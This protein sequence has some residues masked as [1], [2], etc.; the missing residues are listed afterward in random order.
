MNIKWEAEDY[1]S[2]FSFVYK[3][4]ENVLDLIDAPAPANELPA[5]VAAAGSDAQAGAAQPTA[6]AEAESR[7][8]V[9][10][11]A[12]QAV[13]RPAV[14]EAARQAV[15]QP[16][17][18]ADAAA[19]RA[20][21][22][23]RPLAVDLGCGTG[24]L[25]EKLAA[26]GFDVIG[27]DDSADMLS[28]AEDAHPKLRFQK[29]NALDFRL[30]S[31]ADVIFSNAVFHWIDAA[32]QQTLAANLY[33]NL[34]PGGQLV[35]EFGGKGCAEAVHGTLEKCFAARGLTYPRVF[36]FPTIGE[37]A[38]ILEKAGFRVEAAYLF[39]RPT[40]QRGEDGLRRWIDMFIKKPF[41]NIDPDTKSRII[42]D[43]ES[44]LQPV[45]LRD[46]TWFIDYVRIRIKAVKN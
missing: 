28:V 12:R 7:P 25:T 19:A 27:I 20:G 21:A 1:R 38:P 32:D 3:Y 35:C 40:P 18:S 26:M 8:A 42:A 5:A 22:S 34:K 13:T 41:E 14:A 17:R 37:Y 24:A 4:G 36:Y 44:A 45:L 11:A 10:G 43:A 15:T 16:A 23:G 30:E 31:P 46:G 6:A 39:D 9:A 33:R 29:G 2:D